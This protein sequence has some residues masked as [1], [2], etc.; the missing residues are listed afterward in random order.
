MNVLLVFVWLLAGL[1]ALLLV[2]LVV[3]FVFFAEGFDSALVA[4]IC[5]FPW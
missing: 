2:R 5:L 4:V 1:L 3:G